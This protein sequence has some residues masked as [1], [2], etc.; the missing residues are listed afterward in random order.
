MP[1]AEGLIIDSKGTF[2][3][4]N[5]IVYE[6]I[7]KSE[8]IYKE[9]PYK[10]VT[11]DQMMDEMIRRREARR[12]IEGIPDAAE[13]EIRTNTPIVI[14]LFGDQHMAGKEV[15]YEMLRRDVHF[16]AENPKC[17]TILGG[18]VV[19]GAAFNPAQDDKIA[20]FGEET[21]MAIKM[22]D[23][24]GG[25]SILAALQ[26]DH[27]MWSEKGG[28]TLYNSF[29]ERYKTPLMRGSSVIVLKVG[30]IEYRIVCAHQL[31]GNSIYNDTHPENRESKFG[32]Q[33]A[34]I[35][36]GFHNHKKALSQQAVSIAGSGSKMQTFVAGGPYKLTDSYSAKK[37]YAKKE[38]S[39]ESTVGAVWLVLHPYRK[40]VEAF[41]SLDSARERIEPYLTGKLHESKPSKPIDII[42]EIAK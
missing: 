39:N 1:N 31:A 36:A 2:K 22:F 35:Y 38:Q 14:G 26:G 19:D 37:G 12:E 41:W 23:M 17:Y 4:V 21:S 9:D 42:K 15:D 33:G 20:S 34:D 29:R 6:G 16:I 27:D 25:D 13:I 28:A 24:L 32:R 5:E 7:D 40:E 11:F 10:E 18:D 30:D 8:P 3:S